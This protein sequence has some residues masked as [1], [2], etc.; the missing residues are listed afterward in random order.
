MTFNSLIIED[1]GT[2]ECVASSSSPQIA[3]SSQSIRIFVYSKFWIAVIFFII[4]CMY[5]GFP[6]AAQILS[7][8]NLSPCRAEIN[9]TADYLRSVDVRLVAYVFDIQ[10]LVDTMHGEW[11]E[12]IRG[13]IPPLRVTIPFNGADTTYFL[14]VY[15]IIDERHGNT[16]VSGPFGPYV[17]YPSDQISA[18]ARRYIPQV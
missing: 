14:R 8:R 18:L 4:T 6:S 12:L 16:S 17:A 15:G 2:Y 10:F 5:I 1:S 3:N 7:V 9:F 13:R 11:R